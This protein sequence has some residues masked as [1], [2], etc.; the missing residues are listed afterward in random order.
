MVE[1]FLILSDP[2]CI[3]DW[4]EFVELAARRSVR[5]ST[6]PSEIG[7]CRDI[8]QVYLVRW[9]VSGEFGHFLLEQGDFRPDVDLK[10]IFVEGNVPVAA[11]V[12]SL[13]PSI[14]RP[15]ID[16]MDLLAVARLVKNGYQVNTFNAQDIPSATLSPRE[17]IVLEHIASG[18][19]NK[20]IASNLCLS[21]NTIRV[22]VQNILRKL[23]VSNR[24]QAALYFSQNYYLL[25]SAE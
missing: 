12:Q 16:P 3:A 1:E 22:H 4:H 8:S 2:N 5:V 15:N 10:L 11:C 9:P 14:V 20:I 19:S 17:Y 18:K 7:Q 13:R 21:Q 6:S 23:G 25:N 24:T